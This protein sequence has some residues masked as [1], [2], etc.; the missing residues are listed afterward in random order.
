MPDSLDPV[1]DCDF[2]DWDDDSCSICGGD[3][4]TECHDPIQ[5]CNRHFDGSWDQGCVCK[6]CNGTGLA[7]DQ[8][9]W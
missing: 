7:K 1:D 4:Y 5:C 8:V 2:D 9:V 6:A 3:G